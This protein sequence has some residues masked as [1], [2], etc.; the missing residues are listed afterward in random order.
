[1]GDKLAN[2]REELSETFTKVEQGVDNRWDKLHEAR[3]LPGACGTATSIWLKA[4]EA[5]GLTG[6]IPVATYDMASVGLGGFVSKK[7]WVELHDVGSDNISLKMFN[8]N[9]CGNKVST[10]SEVSD[11]FKEVA[12]LGEFKL[13]LRVAR[14]ALSLVH[15][16]NKSL[17]ALE[18]FMFQTDYCKSD[19]TGVEKPALVLTQFSDYI[20]GVN[21]DRW[22]AFQPFVTTGELKGVW[23]SFWGAKPESKI[24]PKSQ[25]GRGPSKTSSISN[26]GFLMTYAECTT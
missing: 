22:R 24:K 10:K 21:A 23:D 11:E 2:N 17:S 6:H 13:A 12:D 7:G 16:W 3:F 19:L 4:R 14:E 8:I 18:G 5:I 15:P 25:G 1:V 26:R 20:M 9:G